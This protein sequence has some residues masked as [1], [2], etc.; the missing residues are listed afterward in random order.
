MAIT[1]LA[2]L[3]AA[4]IKENEE[5]LR[6]YIHMLSEANKLARLTGPSD[7]E[8]LWNEHALDCASALPLLPETGRIIDVGT[9]GGLP[10]MIWAICRPGL[11][12]TL[13]DSIRRKCVLVEKMAAAMGLKNVS[14]ICARSE[15]YAAEHREKFLVATARAVCTAGVLAEYLAPFVKLKGRAIAFKGPRAAEEIEAVGNKWKGLGL[16]SPRLEPYTLDGM[17]RY[18]LIWDKISQTP[19]GIPRRPGMAEKFPW[20][21]R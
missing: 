16:S 9:G 17:K 10:G 19:K 2:E 21:N 3:A 15:E 6:H 14:V 13:L 1:N 8:I 12:V 4:E 20:Y 7:E 18:F 5:K 11:N